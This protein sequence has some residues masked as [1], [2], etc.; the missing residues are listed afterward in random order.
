MTWSVQTGSEVCCII[1][2]VGNDNQTMGCTWFWLFSWKRKPAFKKV[3]PKKSSFKFYCDASTQ[4]H[5]APPHSDRVHTP[6]W[7]PGR[8]P[9]R[10]GLHWLTYDPA[11]EAA[12][13]DPGPFI[14]C[15]YFGGSLLLWPSWRV[16]LTVACW[17]IFILDQEFSKLTAMRH[18]QWDGSI[19][20]RNLSNLY[21]VEQNR[22]E[23]KAQLTPGEI[24]LI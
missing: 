8:D 9:C 18:D 24:S 1:G 15:F 3:D 20:L 23:Q 22:N 21:Y 7:D 13:Q 16:P 12:R 2:A 5:T 19:P 17:N 14:T 10:S 11:S 6:A 4:T